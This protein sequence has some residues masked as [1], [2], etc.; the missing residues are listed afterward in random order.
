MLVSVSGMLIPCRPIDLLPFSLT[1]YAND[2]DADLDAEAPTTPFI[3]GDR[4][5][6]DRSALER[7]DDSGR[8]Y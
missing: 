3:G 6:P 4:R 5:E 7:L 2:H 1:S 8:M